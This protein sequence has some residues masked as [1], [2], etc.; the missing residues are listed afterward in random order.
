M[1]VQAG[2]CEHRWRYFVNIQSRAVQVRE[3]EHCGRRG[4][5]PTELA[6]LPRTSPEKLSA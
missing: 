4:V 3:C 2:P 5:V 6:P 1:K